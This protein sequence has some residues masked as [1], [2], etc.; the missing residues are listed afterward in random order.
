MVVVVVVVV[1]ARGVGVG[2][3]QSPCDGYGV[4]V[5]PLL[6]QDPVHWVHAFD[7]WN[8]AQLAYDRHCVKFEPAHLG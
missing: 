7:A 3:Q 5:F 6:V 1:G 4:V 2:G 8:A